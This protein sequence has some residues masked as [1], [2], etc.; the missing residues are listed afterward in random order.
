MEHSPEG[1]QA[2]KNSPRGAHPAST[3]L[4]LMSAHMHSGAVSISPRTFFHSVFP[5]RLYVALKRFTSW[6]MAASSAGE[7]ISAVTSSAVNK[8]SCL[9]A[10]A[11]SSAV[12]MCA[13]VHDRE[14][15]D[16]RFGLGS[17]S[18]SSLPLSQAAAMLLAVD[19]AIL[20][21]RGGF[22]SYTGWVSSSS[23]S[24]SSTTH[25]MLCLRK[26]TP[27][28]SRVCNA[29]A[30]VCLT[31]VC[32]LGNGDSLSPSTGYFSDEWCRKTQMTTDYRRRIP[33]SRTNTKL[34]RIH[35]TT[36]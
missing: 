16:L 34:C 35:C 28:A 14:E 15:L 36:Y 24:V 26:L 3:H 1:L 33:G 8:S 11:L 32:R 17:A 19:F 12:V 9:P 29:V 18:S 2:V 21:G 27:R 10:A 30:A 4:A 22:S 31:F 6:R 23:S 7:N 13:C 5:C 25:S 20:V